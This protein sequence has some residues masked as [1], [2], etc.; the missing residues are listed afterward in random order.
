M[1]ALCALAL[2]MC[3][4]A[5]SA[6]TQSQ[7][8]GSG[9]YG[10]GSNPNSHFVSPYVNSHGTYVQGHHQTNPNTTQLDISCLC[11]FA[12][13]VGQISGE[14]PKPVPAQSSATAEQ[15]LARRARL[16]LAWELLRHDARGIGDV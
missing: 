1:K 12:C 11:G 13:G 10:T 15:R 7:Y 3:S 8:G 5:A 4:A 14:E 9:L 16:R 2:L 6:W